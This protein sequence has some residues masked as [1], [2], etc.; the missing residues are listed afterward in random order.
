M[1]LAQLS[2]DYNLASAFYIMADKYADPFSNR[3]YDIDS[4]WISNVIH[5][6]QERG[7]E[8]G[9]HPSYF[10]YDD[11][12]RLALEKSR[13]DSVLGYSCYGGRQHFLRFKVPDTWRHWEQVGLKYDSTMTYADHEGFR[14]GTCHAY[15]PFDLEADREI[16]LWEI[17]LIV[18]DGTLLQYRNLEPSQGEEIIYNLAHRCK[19][20]EGTFTLLWHN[21]SLQGEWA[22]WGDMYERV[23]KKL[24]EMI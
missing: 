10:T 2:N 4:P 15:K 5:K 23:V 7:F 18:M 22:P 3:G 12:T 11:P 9:L 19:D 24:S 21:T 13:L 20:V 14:C 6:L 1:Y 16:D 8:I 17:P